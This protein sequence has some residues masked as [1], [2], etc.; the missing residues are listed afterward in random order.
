MRRRTRRIDTYHKAIA[1]SVRW[2]T[3]GQ[4][5]RQNALL[6]GVSLILAFPGQVIFVFAANIQWQQQPK[7]IPQR[8]KN[9]TNDQRF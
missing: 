3:P 4:E 2:T 8:T 7:H 5:N 1:M 9:K 6:I